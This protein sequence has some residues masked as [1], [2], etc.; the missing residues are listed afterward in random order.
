M[1]A[2]TILARKDEVDEE[3]RKMRQLME[4]GLLFGVVFWSILCIGLAFYMGDSES[5]KETATDILG[6]TLVICVFMYYCAPMST[7]YTVIKTRDSSSLYAPMIFINLINAML[8]LF[9][10]SFGVHDSFVA[11][12][13]GAGVILSI[14]QLCFVCIFKNSKPDSAL[15]GALSTN[16]DD[17]GVNSH[18]VK[19]V[20]EGAMTTSLLHEQ[21]EKKI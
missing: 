13:N 19:V 14:I 8:W 7:L 16:E 3:A 2:A 4:F 1:S 12:P 21:V 9:Y 20:Q 18:I 6:Y 10:G 11:I 5:K 15:Y 17:G